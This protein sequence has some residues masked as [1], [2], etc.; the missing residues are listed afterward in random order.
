MNCFNHNETA[1][2]GI[3]KHCNKGIC[4]DCLKDTGDGI[5]C[6]GHCF[7]E[8]KMINDLINHNKKVAKGTTSNWMTSGLLYL[9]LGLIFLLTTVLYHRKI[10]PFL[11]AIGTLSI[12][13]GIYAMIK[14]KS[15]KKDPRDF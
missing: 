3:C 9:F 5:A 4:P 1:A 2:V 7:D 14:S 13:Y 6:K 10:D 12:I 15:Y 8:V 11:S